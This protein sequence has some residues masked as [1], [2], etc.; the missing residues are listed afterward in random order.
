MG[1]NQFAL[2]GN[3]A[4]VIDAVTVQGP[5]GVI[6]TIST[7]SGGQIA[8]VTLPSAKAPAKSPTPAKAAIMDFSTNSVPGG[9]K[10]EITGEGFGT[11]PGT[12]T[13]GN[14]LAI[15]DTNCWTPTAITVDVPLNVP[16]GKAKVTVATKSPS[17]KA[18]SSFTV[19]GKPLDRIQPTNCTATNSAASA[20]TQT[21][22]NSADAT[23]VAPKAGAYSIVPLIALSFDQNGKPQQYMPLDV[24]DPNGK[25]L[26]FTATES[27]SAG[28]T[29]PKGVDSPTTT[30]TISKKTTV[31]PA[32]TTTN[33][34][35]GQ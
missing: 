10:V 33:S 29:T 11:V 13:F 35:S 12:V 3:N 16:P 2:Q 20:N 28:A 26:V 32:A 14:I 30:L 31:T 1:A 15:V 7:V 25:P 19:A 22:G 5:D 8:L 6:N 34:G 17:M 27:K 4:G 23:L 9:T 21:G 24:V 18:T